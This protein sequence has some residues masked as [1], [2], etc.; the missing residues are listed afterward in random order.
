[1]IS[2][3]LNFTL[4]TNEHCTLT[5][6]ELNHKVA[7]LQPII[8]LNNPLIPHTCFQHI[9]D[10]ICKLN[11]PYINSIYFESIKFK[12]RIIS[13][14][15]FGHI[16]GAF[17]KELKKPIPINNLITNVD[18]YKWIEPDFLPKFPDNI[19]E[20]ITLTDKQANC[21]ILATQKGVIHGWNYSLTNTNINY[22]Y[23]YDLHPTDL[24]PI[25]NTYIT[26]SLDVLPQPHQDPILIPTIKSSISKIII[27]KYKNLGVNLKLL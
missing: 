3:T 14:N 4:P 15:L 12:Y 9:S 27:E 8:T 5:I 6:T 21:L 24:I 17:K 19:D 1:M 25:F 22:N 11:R 18:D 26:A 13:F 10:H 2:E 20:I 23:V 7:A 16:R